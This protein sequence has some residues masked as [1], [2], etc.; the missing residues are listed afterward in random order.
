MVYTIAVGGGGM[1]YAAVAHPYLDTCK[2]ETDADR[3]VHE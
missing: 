3:F 2:T 1:A